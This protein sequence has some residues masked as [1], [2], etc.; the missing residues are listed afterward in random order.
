[1]PFVE[2][3]AFDVVRAGARL[4]FG[5]K[6]PRPPVTGYG[7]DKPEPDLR[8]RFERLKDVIAEARVESRR[9]GRPGSDGDRTPR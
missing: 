1:M 5:M 7:Q 2:D 9:R 3:F 4:Y 8:E 6:D